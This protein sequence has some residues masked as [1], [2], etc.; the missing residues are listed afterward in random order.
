MAQLNG[1][2]FTVNKDSLYREEGIT[3]LKIASIRKLVP[4]KSDGTDDPSREA[5]FM[6]HTQLMS[7]SGPLP[8]QAPLKATTLEGAIAEFPSAMDQAVQQIVEEVQK[9][10]REDS[11]R[12]V[13][14]G[15]GDQGSGIIY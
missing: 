15:G 12:I 6:G 1:I 13:T 3:D 8:V 7:P 9:M 2:D 14:P 11:S 4:I 10:Q 5:V